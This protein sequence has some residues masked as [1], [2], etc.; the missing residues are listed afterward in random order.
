MVRWDEGDRS[1]GAAC[2]LARSRRRGSCRDPGRGAAAGGG[3]PV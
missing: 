3:A 1:I 2:G